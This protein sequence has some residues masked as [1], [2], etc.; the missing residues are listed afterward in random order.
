MPSCF[1]LKS[2]NEACLPHLKIEEAEFLRGPVVRGLPSWL[3]GKESSC[4]CR[5]CKRRGSRRSPG[6][7]NDNP[8]QYS[9]L[10]DFMDT[11]TWW[12][13][14]CGVAESDTT[15]YTHRRTNGQ[16]SVRSLLGPR[17]ASWSNN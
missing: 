9:C 13:T 16:D 17:F 11:G 15:E 3:S 14:V 10:E 8:L 5:R 12:A 1:I 7:G 2:P 4:Q 6:V